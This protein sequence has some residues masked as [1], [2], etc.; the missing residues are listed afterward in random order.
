MV[1]YILMLMVL[2]MV[3]NFSCQDVLKMYRVALEFINCTSTHPFSIPC[4]FVQGKSLMAYIFCLKCSVKHEYEQ[5]WDPEK[6]QLTTC[7]AN[8]K[9][10]VSGV[11]TPQEVGEGKEVIFTYDVNFEVSSRCL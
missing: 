1:E 4:L 10:Y 6:P 3:T 7:N 2:C 9:H 5:P 8:T 11:N